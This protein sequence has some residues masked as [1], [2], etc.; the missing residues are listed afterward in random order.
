MAKRHNHYAKADEKFVK[1]TIIFSNGDDNRAFYDKECTEP[2]YNDEAVD[3]FLD[4]VVFYDHIVDSYYSIEN[5]R[6]DGEYY[7]LAYLNGTCFLMTTRRP[8]EE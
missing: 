8:V 5:V 4:G 6:K 7:N 3:L 2:V 1:R